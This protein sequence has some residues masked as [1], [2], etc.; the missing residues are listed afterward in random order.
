MTNLFFCYRSNP[1][2]EAIEQYEDRLTKA[3]EEIY[4]LRERFKVIEE[5]NNEDITR[6]VEERL[7]TN[8]IKE[9]NGKLFKN[10]K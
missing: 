9:I 8:S 2:S 3:N 7:Q 4:K 6:I 10:F 1:A 5:G